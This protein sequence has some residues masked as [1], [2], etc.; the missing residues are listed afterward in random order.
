MAHDVLTVQMLEWI[1]Q[2][3]PT[4]AELIDVWK[5]TCPRLA[6]WEDACA[7]GLIDYDPGSG[8]FLTEKGRRLL[9]RADPPSA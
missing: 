9:D 8:F 3:S 5:S 6:I 7:S 2:R 1:A 4:Y